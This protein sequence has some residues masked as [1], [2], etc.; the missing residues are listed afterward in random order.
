MSPLP[1]LE[2]LAV[3]ALLQTGPQEA[4][5][6]M[7]LAE[8]ASHQELVTETRLHPEES[9]EAFREL[10]RASPT[11]PPQSAGRLAAAYSEAWTDPFL[12]NRYRRFLGWSLEQR[13]DKLAADSLR[14]AGNEAYTTGGVDEALRPWR[15]SLAIVETLDDTSG[16]ARSLGNIGAGY[17]GAGQL[18]SA[19]V[20]YERSHELALAGGDFVAAGNALTVLALLSKDAGDLAA[21]GSL[22]LRALGLHERVGALRSAG[23]DHHNLGLVALALGD[24]EEARSE[25]EAA[26]EISQRTGRQDDEADHLSS[27]ADVMLAGGDYEAAESALSR[28]LE[29]DLQTGNRLGEAGVR[30][31][32]GLLMLVRGDYV[33]AV[34][35]L[36]DAL[37]IY[38][39]M[40]RA[41]DAVSAMADLA[42]A[43]AATG[44]VRRGTLDLREA[45]RLAETGQL[46]SAVRADLALA[47]GDFALLLNEY[48]QAQ[49][50][51]REAERLYRGQADYAGIAAALHGQAFVHLYQ[52]RFE[53]AV[54]ALEQ[55][56]RSQQSLGDPRAAAL[57]RLLLADV[58]LEA[59]ETEEARLVASDARDVLAALGDPVGEAAALA[60]LAQTET[61]AGDHETAD[62]RYREALVLIA[63]TEAPGI[64]WRLHSGRAETLA[65]RGRDIEARDQ[66]RLAIGEIERAAGTW[67]HTR[68]G[69]GYLADK[70]EVYARLARLES[71]LGDPEMAFATSERLRAQRLLGLLDRGRIGA[72]VPDAALVSREQDLRLRIGDLTAWLEPARG[73]EG[74]LRGPGATNLT[75]EQASA[76]LERTRREYA[77]VLEDMRS[78]GAA[79][80]ELVKPELVSGSDLARHLAADEL[81]LEYLVT[82]SSVLIFGITTDGL[83]S[84]EIP[85][86]RET[87]GDLIG[88][89]RGVLADAARGSGTELWRVPLKRLH[90]IL[91]EPLAAAGWL[92]GREHLIVVPHG[93]LHYLPFQALIDEEDGFLIGRYSV[94]YAPSATVWAELGARPSRVRGGGILAMAP[95]V[96]ELPASRREM[97]RI[98]DAYGDQA[99]ILLG[100]EATEEALASTAGT[101]DVIH[102]A[103][104]GVLNRTN[105]LFSYVELGAGLTSDGRLEA[106][107][108]FGM[109][110]DADLVVLS[111]CETG[112]ASGSRA[113]VPPGDDWVGLVRSFLSAGASEVIATLW[114]VEDRTTADLMSRFYQELASGEPARIALA[115][116]QRQMLQ[117]PATASPFYWAGFVLV[118]QSGGSP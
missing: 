26:L 35:E 40:G 96:A 54:N 55:A 61:R 38:Q 112:L 65:A 79:H 74:P 116:A 51:Y 34:R 33:T 64:A 1:L 4:D 17:Y 106:H 2:T 53:S 84:M 114:R 104:Y 30:H 45:C 28:A 80:I 48:D 83:Q 76:A 52:T 15:E 70:W 63:G 107:E 32:M 100:A 18:D 12:V 102:L 42:R 85:E 8:A 57:T 39:S 16:V 9:R 89:T 99:T 98:Q 20:Y 41:V 37:D 73:A 86:T 108:I 117:E 29:L 23:F 72:T 36:Q 71:R 10:L 43:R 101:Y 97:A 59:D 92:E 113:D 25:L 77:L 69:A 50:D 95:R 5:R 90:G 19:T 27:L 88:F 24:L 75:P 110:L 68:S 82:D 115:A 6:L 60:V 31:S 103:T 118:G 11:H 91:I 7:V 87:L 67:T 49:S 94:S 44:D 62:S 78:A 14:R 3:A 56:L 22:G 93:E 58:R 105:P 81:F 47:T 111:A 21:A 13:T 46:G 66:L 109:H